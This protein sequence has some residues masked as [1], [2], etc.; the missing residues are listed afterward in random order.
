LECVVLAERLLE[1]IQVTR[2][3]RQRFH[4]FDLRAVGLDGKS[5]T[6]LDRLA[7]VANR[8]GSAVTRVATNFWAPQSEIITQE[9]NQQLSG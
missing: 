9:V 6:T 7:V 1:Y 5:H 3:T 2:L 4:G 8:A